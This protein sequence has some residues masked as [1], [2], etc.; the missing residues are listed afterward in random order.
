MAREA[1]AR[2]VAVVAG[3]SRAQGGIALLRRTPASHQRRG[4][5]VARA[6]GRRRSRNSPR[7]SRRFAKRRSSNRIGP[8]RFSGLARTF[9]YGLEDVDRGA[10]ALKQA[11]RHGYTP[12]QRETVQLADGYRA[13]GDTLVRN[14]RQLDG[15]PQERDYLSRAVNAYRQALTLYSDAVDY[16][17]VPR[18]I[19]LTQRSLEQVEQRISEL[20]Q[21]TKEP[22][23][24]GS[25][26]PAL[27]SAPIDARSGATLMT[28]SY[29]PAIERDVNA[30][31][32]RSFGGST[33]RHG[34]LPLTS[35][36]AILAIGLAYSGRTQ[37]RLGRRQ[38]AAAVNL[39]TVTSSGD[40]RGPAGARFCQS[41]RSRVRR[42]GAVAIRRAP[43]AGRQSARTSARLREPQ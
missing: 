25:D 8:I 19:R 11:Q 7:R 36:V 42:T 3:R 9:I 16:A 29:V 20:D 18:Y 5:K 27:E 24:P 6:S 41:G 4:A 28:V 39:N 33:R 14:A 35:M 30:R 22:P 21:A 15:M 38:S 2:A 10:D 40:A 26:V 32:V 31:S 23:P 13:R 17:N 1:L 34:L 43:P 12:A 37:Q